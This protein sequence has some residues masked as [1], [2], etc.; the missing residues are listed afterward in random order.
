MILPTYFKT[1]EPTAARIEDVPKG[2]YWPVDFSQSQYIG[3]IHVSLTVPTG[4]NWS[5]RIR[6]DP[7]PNIN[8]DV[9]PSYVQN[10]NVISYD[11][12]DMS[13]RPPTV[14][15]VFLARRQS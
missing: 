5:L 10:G 4:Q 6:T 13:F 7:E 9:I 12:S 14:A 11:A 1:I 15:R 2:G 3:R 8:A